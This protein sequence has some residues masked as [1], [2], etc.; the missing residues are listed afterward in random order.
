MGLKRAI[1]GPYRTYAPLPC[2]RQLPRH[3]KRAQICSCLGCGDDFCAFDFGQSLG[4][5]RVVALNPAVL[6]INLPRCWVHA[7]LLP[8]VWMDDRNS[9]STRCRLFWIPLRRCI[10]IRG[11]ESFNALC[12]IPSGVEPIQYATS[13]N[14]YRQSDSNVWDDSMSFR[15]TDNLNGN[16]SIRGPCLCFIFNGFLAFLRGNQRGVSTQKG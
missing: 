12:L 5:F 6:V 9:P 7:P 1:Y 11:Q 10:R 3:L 14:P 16:W 8:F 15:Y 4:C 2:L 13:S